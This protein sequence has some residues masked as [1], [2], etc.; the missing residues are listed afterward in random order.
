MALYVKQTDTRSQLQEKLAQELQ[1][2]A[3]EK[4]KEAE[5]PDGVDDSAYIEGTKVTSSLAWAWILII[6]AI[7][8]I[9]IWLVIVSASK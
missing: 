8:G 7:I 5:L 9:A 3:R 2:K 1:D 4:A 6:V